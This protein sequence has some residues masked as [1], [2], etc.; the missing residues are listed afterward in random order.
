MMFIYQ[1]P[2][3]GEHEYFHLHIEFYPILRDRNKL[4]YAAG[5]E[6]GTWDFT[7]DGVPEEN[8]RELRRA[9]R[10]ALEKHYINGPVLGSCS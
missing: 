1:A 3:K 4:K 6:L 10:M 8:A 7:Y 5:I 9:C 2:L